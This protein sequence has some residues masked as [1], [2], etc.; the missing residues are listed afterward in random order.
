VKLV[1]SSRQVDSFREKLILM[2]MT[3]LGILV[4]F[5]ALLVFPAT[6]LATKPPKDNPGQGHTPVTIC[7]HAGPN[8]ENWHT[9]TVDD[10]SV[11][12]RAHLG[13]GDTLGPCPT[14]EQPP[15][16]PPVTP[17]EPPVTPV[18]PEQPPVDNPP[19]TTPKPDAPVKEKKSKKQTIG[20][21]VQK[22][23]GNDSTPAE[24]PATV[25]TT[26][27][28]GRLPHTGIDWWVLLLMGAGLLGT[29]LVLRY[30]YSTDN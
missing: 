5:V 17:E 2:L 22:S 4:A 16:E 11:T 15:E 7:H 10:D 19:V 9:I 23:G 13:H 29:G 8:P 27:D 26:A 21:P 6:G 24:I 3:R 18:T 30:K 1:H 25:Q 20:K 12:L 14:V 28:T